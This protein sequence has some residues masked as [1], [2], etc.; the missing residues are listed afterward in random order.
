[1]LNCSEA[2]LKLEPCASGTLGP[3]DKIAL[4]EH[5]A[6]CEGCRLELELTRAV[7]GAPAFEGVD[8]PPAPNAPQALPVPGAPEWTPGSTPGSTPIGGVD[9]EVSFAD[10][11]LD[12]PDTNPPATGAPSVPPAVG[13][14]PSAP[15]QSGATAAGAPAEAS[16][17]LWDFEPVD[18]PRDAGPPEDSLSFANAALSRKRKDELKRKA[19]L[20]R[21]ALWGGGVGCGLALLG[22]SVWIAL[23]F[24]Q[25]QPEPPRQP[26]PS[27]SVPSG[28]VPPDPMPWPTT[29][30][31]AAGATPGLAADPTSPA[32]TE[33]GSAPAPTPAPTPTVSGDRGAQ[34]APTPR[35]TEPQPAAAKPKPKSPPKPATKP[36]PKPPDEDA[37]DGDSEAP[38]WSPSDLQPP[39]PTASPRPAD[40]SPGGSPTPEPGPAPGTQSGPAGSPPAGTTPQP[41][42]GTAPPASPAPSPAADPGATAPPPPAPVVTRPIDRL[43]L[44]TV[45][46]TENQDLVT[47]RKLKDS[48]KALIRSAAGPE[49]PR[50]KRELADCLWAIQ[51]ITGKLSDRREALAAYRDYVLNAPAGG[52]DYRS[53]SRMRYLEDSLAESD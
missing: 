52:T 4:E 10:L 51:E 41:S 7:L 23:A 37:T 31:S 17:S 20:V 1:M 28:Q 42:T 15:G 46:A 27:P 8:E 12:S 14:M 5:L 25:G 2:R 22:I 39:P 35:D 21:L 49:R 29:P 48:W 11:A 32:T 30:D 3:E 34:V 36:T 18:A 40:K 44:A 53:I 45:T 13:G 24:R 16:T 6:T 26:E 50:A 38:E 47:L 9:E 43:H 33:A 19:M